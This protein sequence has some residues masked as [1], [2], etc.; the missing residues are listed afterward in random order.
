MQ[1]TPKVG[2][3]LSNIGWRAKIYAF[4][5]LLTFGTIAVGIVG[6][7]AIFYLNDSIQDAV[8][9]ARERAAVAANAR[10]SVIGIDRAQARLVSAETPNEVRREAVAAIRAASY[11]DESLQTLENTLAGNPMVAE[12]IA[13]NQ[14]VTST[15]MV[16]I[17]AA[18]G[19]DTAK[20]QEEMRAI[21]DKIARIEELSNQIFSD[22][23]AQ[24]TER[25]RETVGVSKRIMFLLG[26]FVIASA[27]IAVTVSLVFARQLAASIRGI[28]RTVGSVAAGQSDGS[29]DL[30]LA[31]HA[32][33][34]AEI[35][36]DI[37]GC[38]ERMAVSINHIKAGTFNVR[39]ATDESGKQLDNAVAHI[40]KMAD[41]VAANA[42][43]IARIVEQFEVMKSEMQSAIGTTQGLQRSVGNISAIANT[44]SEISS[45]TNLLALNAAIE[46]ARAGEHGRGFAVV[47][48]E[49][50]NLAGRTG[51]A[52]Q[53]IHAIAHGIDNEVGKAV[54]S[55]DK[56]AANARQYAGQLSEVL[57][58][59]TATAQGA[60]TARQLMDAVLSQ[61]TVQREAVSLI[62][63][64][65]TEVEST[66]ALSQEQSTTLRGVSDA[67]SHSAQRLAEL[68]DKLK[69]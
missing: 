45:Q 62:E 14:Q 15:R 21:S 12:L 63:E 53:E 18:K 22:E 19:R 50:R 33:Q 43:S 57:E 6:G 67:L 41:S 3:A 30:A 1:L 23:Q 64:Q 68:A 65:L 5:G 49:V 61:M 4:A 58:N 48:G 69:L 8:G 13:L 9:K 60:A 59:S 52:T 36:S 24:L 42:A 34:V 26:A 10:L 7:I 56:S 31:A 29:N 25:V 35:A 16:I 40:Q 20:A 66:M 38:E 39:S 11:L 47:A 54:T 27:T 55:L 46:A 32:G 28:Q 44:I 37:S 17:K 51:Q 2:A